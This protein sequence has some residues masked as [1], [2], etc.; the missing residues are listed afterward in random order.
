MNTT[1]RFK[2]Y[3][4]SKGISNYRAEQDCGFSNGLI[5]NALKTGS[6]LG[7]D[8][9]ESILNAY[10]DLSAEWLL[11]GTGEMLNV[12]DT[13]K[14][15]ISMTNG[16]PYYN[17]DFIGGFDL[18]LND[19][20]TLPEYNIDFQPYNKDGVV[21]CNITGHSMEPAIGHGDIIAIKEIYDWKSYITYGEIYALVT[22][23]ELRTVKIVRKGCDEDHYRLVPINTEE[24]DEQQIEK[25]QIAR[26]FSVLGCVKKM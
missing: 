26:V 13:P 19:Q 14:P 6:S 18:V 21:W 11:R 12:T 22:R 3:L 20:T 1:D 24:Y 17:V 9:L 15:V 8:K 23:N 25:S 7:S 16:R 5:G 10:D 2:T 4:D